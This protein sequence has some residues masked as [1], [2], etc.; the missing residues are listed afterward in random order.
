MSE[1]DLYEE[2]KVPPQFWG[3]VMLIVFAVVISGFAMWAHHG[4]PDPPRYFD[5]GALKDTPAESIY[6]SYHS[7]PVWT[8]KRIVHELPEGKPLEPENRPPKPGRY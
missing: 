5:H 8:E 2:Y 3:W 1:Q 6:S 7:S 4:I